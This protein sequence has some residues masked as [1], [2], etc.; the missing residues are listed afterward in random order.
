MVLTDM[1]WGLCVV[2]H[3]AGGLKGEGLVQ[4]DELLPATAAMACGAAGGA[5]RDD[6]DTSTQ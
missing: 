4:N 3:G 1:K 5:A 6:D 2:A